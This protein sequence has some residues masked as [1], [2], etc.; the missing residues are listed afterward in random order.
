MATEL[1]GSD[2]IDWYKKVNFART[3]SGIGMPSIT[4]TSYE[5]HE[6]SKRIKGL[7]SNI[8]SSINGNK[9]LEMADNSITNAEY[10]IGKEI[11]TSSKNNINNT[12]ISMLRVCPN[13]NCQTVCSNTGTNSNQINTNGVCSNVV[14]GNGAN[15]NGV[16]SNVAHSNVTNSNGTNGNGQ[17]SNG[18]NYIYCG[19]W[20]GHDNTNSDGYQGNGTCNNG[21]N[22]NGVNGNGTNSNGANANGVCN[23]INNSNGTNSN[24]I[25]SNGCTDKIYDPNTVTYSAKNHYS[26]EEAIKRVP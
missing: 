21:V 11:K 16:C 5:T 4:E 2:V 24:G 25:K 26:E 17:N 7:V 10:D 8:L 12:V 15:S 13:I 1:K 9:F 6:T 3:Q 19:A 20:N 22:S 23:N 18:M 14:K